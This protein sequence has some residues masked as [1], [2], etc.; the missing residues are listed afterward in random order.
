MTLVDLN[1][2]TVTATS[3][4]V[5]LGGVTGVLT[6]TPDPVKPSRYVDISL[7]D[8]DNSGAGTASVTINSR[9]TSGGTINET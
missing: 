7:T 4:S 8:T 2:T 9:G 6:L 1:E 5:K 3:G